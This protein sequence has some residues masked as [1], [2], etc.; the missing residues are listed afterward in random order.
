MTMIHF[1]KQKSVVVAVVGVVVVGRSVDV[2]SV[3]LVDVFSH[4]P[5]MQSRAI[6]N[7]E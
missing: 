1:E 4:A 2:V 5:K 7:G 3:G 6:G